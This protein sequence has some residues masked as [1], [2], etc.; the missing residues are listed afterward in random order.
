MNRILILVGC[1]ITLTCACFAEDMQTQRTM[2]PKQYKNE[3]ERFRMEAPPLLYQKY[4]NG[5]R[6]S[7]LGLAITITGGVALING[8]WIAAFY[9]M[10]DSGI[11]TECFVLFAVG[12]GGVSTGVPLIIKG[13]AKKRNAYNTFR[14]EYPA[15]R[16]SSNF[17]LNLYGNG[18]GFAY[19]F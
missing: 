16:T 14:K 3:G 2:Q 10:F 5:R 17:Q 12:V 11:P 7:N 4:R 19:V 13:G 6:M 18:L 15:K 9:S 8:V 1:F